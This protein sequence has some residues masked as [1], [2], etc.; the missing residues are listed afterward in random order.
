MQLFLKYDSP[1]KMTN[2]SYWYSVAHEAG[3]YQEILQ[4][5]PVSILRYYGTWVNE[6]TGQLC[7]VL[8]SIGHLRADKAGWSG[9]ME[10]VRW[11]G[12]FHSVVQGDI[13]HLSLPSLQMYDTQFY[14][15]CAQE[16]L[17]KVFGFHERYD[18]LLTLCER[19]VEA[20]SILVEPPLVL[21]HGEYYPHN[22]LV[23]DGT[24]YPVDWQ[25]AAIARGELDLASLTEGWN[26]ARI[27]QG[28][29]EYERSR[30][31][32]GTPQEFRPALALARV[33]W[34]LRWLGSHPESAHI[35]LRR[36]YLEQAR[37]QGERAGLL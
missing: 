2:Q 1:K 7:L 24:V 36:R 30:W 22:V 26:E 31:S 32:G 19:F 10:A 21:V 34:P 15:R 3:V 29:R 8:Q 33:Y 9:L 17:S 35:P 6:A 20:A 37:F 11:L 12:H 25:S 5:L 14:A 23:S 16:A 4:F 13:S 18:W 28:E 27:R